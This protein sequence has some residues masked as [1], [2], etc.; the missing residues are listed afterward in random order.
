MHSIR[1]RRIGLTRPSDRQHPLEAHF[2]SVYQRNYW[3]I[4]RLCRRYHVK[5]EDA[6]DLTHEVFIRYIQNYEHFRHDAS[7]STWMYRVAVNLCILRWRK[8]KVRDAADQETSLAIAEPSDPESALLD[9]LT[10]MKIMSHYP[11]RVQK[12]LF[13]LHVEKRTQFEIG[14]ALGISRST[15]I[16]DLEQ[17]K[18]NLPPSAPAAGRGGLAPAP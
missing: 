18:K 3:N 16:R 14:E 5:S 1:P 15:V 8:E 4:Y 17:V 9:K 6:K 7:P 10:L 2:E 13:M 11:K 12:I